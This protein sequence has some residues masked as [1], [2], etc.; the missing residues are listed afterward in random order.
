[1]KS[2]FGFGEREREMQIFKRKV[3]KEKLGSGHRTWIVS[4]DGTFEL[5]P[6]ALSNLK[7]ST[8][9]IIRHYKGC[10]RNQAQLNSYSN[11]A[12]TGHPFGFESRMT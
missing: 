5:D 11:P 3:R 2:R 4:M 7:N 10:S 1:M 12:H 6:S 8:K 9:C